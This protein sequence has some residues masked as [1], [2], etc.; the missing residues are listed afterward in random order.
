MSRSWFPVSFLVLA[1]L[2]MM[3][4]PALA[5]GAL[6]VNVPEPSLIVALA[7]LTGMGFAGWLWQ[8]R[9]RRP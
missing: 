5:G 2:A 1:A 6:P 8:R 7:G 9:R 3:A 4:G